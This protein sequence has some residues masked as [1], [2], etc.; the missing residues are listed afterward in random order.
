MARI[1]GLFHLLIN[2]EI[3]WGYNSPTDPIT[4]DPF[5]FRPGTSKQEHALH[6]FT[7]PGAPFWS[8]LLAMHLGF[9]GKVGAWRF[10]MWPA[11]FGMA[12]SDL[13]KIL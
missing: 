9:I 4:I 12:F 7:F 2:G 6:P 5:T 11:F 1:N 10:W 13:Y 8:A 3:S